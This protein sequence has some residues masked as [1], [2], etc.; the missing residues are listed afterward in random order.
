MSP[1]NWVMLERVVF[2]RDDDSFPDESRAPIRA[3]GITT[4]NAKFKIAFDLAPPPSIT[5]LYVHLP[6]FPKKEFPLAIVATHQ[7]LILFRV[8]TMMS[9]SLVQDFFIYDASDTSSSPSLI[10]IPPCVEPDMDYSRRDGSLPSGR[11]SQGVRRLLAVKSMGLLCRGKEEFA[12]AQLE[13]YK[14]SSSMVFADIYLFLKSA[15]KWDNLRLPVLCSSNNPKDMWQVCLWQT[16]TVIPADRYLCWIDY[17]RGILFYDV[18]GEPHPTV[19]FRR[20]PLD[21]F[22]D[23][24]TRSKACSWLY[25]SVSAIHGGDVLMFINVARNDDIGY[26]ALKPGA[27]FTITC[28]TLDISPSSMGLRRVE[29]EKEYTVTS[30][31]A[32][33]CQPWKPPTRHSYVPPSRHRQATCSALS[34][35]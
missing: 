20:F 25:R 21:K 8:G 12:V 35:Q 32:L 3:T 13:L 19:F 1:P 34:L 24:Q 29:W 28:H 30:D 15:G 23:T 4:W 14:R 7:H 27:G 11:T 5:R 18:F 22:P 31:E 9:T 16:D 33:V 26:G 6:S 10:E 2:R 17:E